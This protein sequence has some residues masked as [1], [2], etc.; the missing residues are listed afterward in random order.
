MQQIIS[1]QNA[2]ISQQSEMMTNLS[3]IRKRARTGN[4]L[5]IGSLIQNHKRNK[6]LSNIQDG[7][8]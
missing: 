1:N 7:L 4:F 2:A 8:K 3:K 6:M 5:N